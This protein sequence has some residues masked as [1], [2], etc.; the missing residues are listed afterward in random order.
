VLCA[1]PQHMPLELLATIPPIV[2]ATLLAGS[3]PSL[4]P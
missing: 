3:G 4:R 2:Q 1:I